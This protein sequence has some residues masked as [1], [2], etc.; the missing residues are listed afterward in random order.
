MGRNPNVQKCGWPEVLRPVIRKSRSPDADGQKSGWPKVQ[1]TRSPDIGVPSS[2]TPLMSSLND[3][4]LA[5][6][7]LHAGQ[8]ALGRLIIMPRKVDEP[9]VDDDHDDDGRKGKKERQELILLLLPKRIIREKVSCKHIH[10]KV[11][12]DSKLRKYY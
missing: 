1:I 5:A 12:M 6:A 2:A 10:T 7:G 4:Q 9:R 11:N 8:V 3:G